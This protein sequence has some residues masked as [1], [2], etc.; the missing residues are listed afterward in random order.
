MAANVASALRAVDALEILVLVDNATDSLS[1]VPAGVINENASLRDHGGG[2]VEAVKRIHAANGGRR[3]PFHANEG[4][5]VTRA[6]S[7]PGGGVI[8]FRDVPKAAELTAAGADVVISP[9]ARLLLDDHFYL[10]GEIP[11][12]TPYE[13]GFPGHLK[14]AADGVSWEPDPLLLDERY[15]AVNVKGKG[16]VIFSMCSHAGIVNVLTHARA[17]FAGTALHAVIGGF[18]L[19]GPTVE[20]AILETVRDLLGF[21]L[22]RIIPAHCTGWR[23][24]TA[25]ANAAPEDVLVPSAV[26]R[27]FLF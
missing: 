1:S 23:A 25:M 9:D 6:N 13:H 2:L 22:K 27:R 8:A 12:V 20:P 14:R 5:F 16:A 19:A 17:A 11:R 10:S 24:F 3:V 4:M 15:L 26:G 18:H 21:G 7:L